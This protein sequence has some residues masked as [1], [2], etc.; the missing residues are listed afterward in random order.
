[1]TYNVI[2]WNIVIVVIWYALPAQE[3]GTVEF[4]C[5]TAQVMRQWL[6]LFVIYLV[7]KL[8]CCF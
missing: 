3:L 5:L 2:L 1:M 6:S 4:Y 7:D 8:A